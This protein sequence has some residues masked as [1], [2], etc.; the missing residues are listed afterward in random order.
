MRLTVT[1]DDLLK[2]LS[3]VSSV[4]ERRQANAVLT[5]VLVSAGDG[6][7]VLTGTDL[8]LEVV[9]RCPAEVQEPGKVTV[10]GRKFLDIVRALPGES[11]L[12]CE[13][14][15]G[16]FRV[17]MAKSR[18][19]LATL[20]VEDFPNLL[21][22]QWDTEFSVSRGDFR[23]AIEKTQFCMAQQD[24]RYYLNGVMLE[25]VGTAL[26]AIAADGH[27]LA[28]C[29][30]ETGCGFTGERQVI[31][32]RKAVAELARFLG[33]GSAP[34]TISLSA[35]HIRVA[36]DNVVFVSKLVD[37][38]FPDYHRVIPQTVKYEVGLPRGAVLEMLGRVGVVSTE[39]FRGIRLRFQGATLAASATNTDRDEAWEELELPGPVPDLEIGFNVTYLV[40]AIGALEEGEFLFGWNDSNGGVR[41][42]AGAS[43]DNQVYVVMPVRL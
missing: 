38:R 43:G 28:L 39:K 41:L 42:K 18:Y 1:R 4:V 3:V 16:R 31:V 33:D 11:I 14:E 2:V 24:V 12:R 13:L 25:M 5:H 34:I 26:K 22:V 7:I 23:R 21:D 6:E 8:E 30:M 32:P 35:N 36:Q 9:A 15:A 29:A 40:E 27:R 19:Q 20:P 37:G 10:P 17:A